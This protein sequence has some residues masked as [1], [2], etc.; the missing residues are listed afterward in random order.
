LPTIQRILI[1][2]DVNEPSQ[3][4]L[5]H[6]RA[7]A[8]R[9]PTELHLLYVIPAPRLPQAMDEA[10]VGRLR[11]ARHQLE[12]RAQ[13]LLMDGRKVVFEVR[14]GRP[15]REIVAYARE[16]EIDQVF[17]TTHARTGLA[18]AVLGSVAEQVIRLAPCPVLVLRPPR[19][20]PTDDRSRQVAAAQ[21]LATSFGSRLNGSYEETRELMVSVLAR[22]LDLEFPDASRILDALMS[23]HALAW[24]ELPTSG[25]EP[26]VSYW[27][28][29]IPSIMG[30]TATVSTP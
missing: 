29:D 9:S 15:A 28:I 1:P 16:N 11:A 19:H 10:L 24:N 23:V 20:R 8:E 26:S 12:H 2:L 4:V 30:P 14:S 21:V 25:S 5:T 27:S 18:H 3:Q 7:L 17:M 6:A 13:P 22:D